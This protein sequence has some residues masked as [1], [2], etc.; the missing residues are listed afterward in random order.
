MVLVVTLWLSDSDQLL[1]SDDVVLS[2]VELDD[3][4]FSPD[5]SLK[6]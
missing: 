6:R 1:V 4:S 3:D 2:E 5:D